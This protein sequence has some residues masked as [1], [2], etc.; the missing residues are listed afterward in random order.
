MDQHLNLLPWQRIEAS[1]AEGDGVMETLNAICNVLEY[2]VPDNYEGFL[3]IRYEC[4]GGKAAEQHGGRTVIRF[5][6][7]GVACV[8][9]RYRDMYPTGISHT[10]R[11]QTMSGREVEYIVPGSP[12]QSGQGLLEGGLT[13]ITSDSTGNEPPHLFTVFYGLGKYH[14]LNRYRKMEYT[15]QKRLNFLKGVLEYHRTHRRVFRRPV[16]VVV[17]TGLIGL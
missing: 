4:P 10:A 1:A 6:S 7:N 13:T 15:Q 2:T 11:I 5:E 9:Q 16:E 17:S 8:R 12:P 3:V 14:C